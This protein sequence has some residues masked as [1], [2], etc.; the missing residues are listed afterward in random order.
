MKVVWWQGGVHFRPESDEDIEALRGM[1]RVIVGIEKVD[2]LVVSPRI[3]LEFN[4][5]EPV[6]G[7]EERPELVAQQS[8]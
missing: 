2:S 8:G 4:D 1:L 3:G 7:V 6:V 5:E